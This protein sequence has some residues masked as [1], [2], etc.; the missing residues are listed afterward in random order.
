[1]SARSVGLLLLL[2]LMA[3]T[4]V[5]A[6]PGP[7]D[8]A[9]K[10]AEQAAAAPARGNLS[11]LGR[12]GP[13]P[14]GRPLAGGVP[15][16]PSGRQCRRPGRRRGQGHRRRPGRRRRHR[17]GLARDQSRRIGEGRLGPGRGQ[18][19]RYRHDQPEE[20]L[21]RGDPP[22]GLPQAGP[23]R[24][25]DRQD[26]HDLGGAPGEEGPDPDPRLHP[27]RRLRRRG[28]LGRLSR[29]APGGPGRGRR[30]R[31]SGPGRGRPARPAGHRLQQR[32]LR[33]RRQDPG[34]R[35]RPGHRPPRS[36]RERR[37]RSGR[38]GLRH[39]RR[40]HPGHRRRRLSLAPRPR[41]LLRRQGEARPAA[42]RGVPRMGPCRRPGVRRRDGLHRASGRTGS[43]PAWPS[44][45][46]RRR[47]NEA[48]QGRPG[49]AGDGPRRRP[50]GP[51]RPARRR[52][53]L[54]QVAGHPPRRAAVEAPLLPGL[55]PAQGRVRPPAVH[56]R[57]ASG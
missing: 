4:S 33:L 30:L 35:D 26:R 9:R 44:S 34:A 32:Q 20:P 22:P 25:L 10:A 57:D 48:S 39:A 13:L 31:R 3:G 40:P 37:R 28:D 7:A 47:R 23:G 6:E 42:P 27:L 11:S 8:A 52:R 43:L 18:G 1:M 24:R 51:P 41:S 2:A 5:P 21:P 55:A 46:A 19:R 38:E 45:A 49:P 12:L 54:P 17:D 56:H 36:R 16:E 50:A 15:E 53:A 29:R 14:P